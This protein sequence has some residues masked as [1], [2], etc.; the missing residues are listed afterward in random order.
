MLKYLH[1]NFQIWFPDF[2]SP[3]Y[4]KNIQVCS[5]RTPAINVCIFV[6]LYQGTFTIYV[7]KVVS[8]PNINKMSTEAAGRSSNVNVE[9]FLQKN[10]QNLEYGLI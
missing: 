6:Y 9:L 7:G 3:K 10:C 8:L 2:K 4:I 1:I 5:L